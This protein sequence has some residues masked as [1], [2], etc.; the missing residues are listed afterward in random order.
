M[1]HLYSSYKRVFATLLF[2]FI[3][4]YSKANI[5]LVTNT[6]VSGP[7]SF[8]DALNQANWHVGKD[9]I[10]FNI[11]GSGPFVLKPDANGF[12]NI[13]DGVYI[14]GYSQPG[15]TAGAFTSRKILIILDGANLPVYLSG[16]DII[17]SNVEIAGLNVRNFGESGIVIGGGVQNISVWG[18][19]IGTNETGTAA[20]SNGR[21]GVRSDPFA[22]ANSTNI[23]IGTNGDGV[24]DAWEGNIISGNRDNGV[25]FMLVKNSK[26]SGNYIGIGATGTEVIGNSTAGIVLDKS[27]KSNLIGTDGNGTSDALEGNVIGNNGKYG[28]W[29]YNSSDSNTVAGNKI[30]LNTSNNAAP[31][32]MGIIVWNSS[33][34][35][36]GVTNN[37]VQSNTVS[38][39]TDYGIKLQAGDYFA[40]L[41]GNTTTHNMIS[42]N[43]I[44][45]FAPGVADR[46]NGIF[47][48]YAESL[49]G[50]DVINN[51]I[52]SNND[53]VNDALE[54]NTIAFNKQ[55]GVSTYTGFAG[56]GKLTGL[57]ISKNRMYGNVE[58]GIDLKTDLVAG[59][60]VSNN[61]N[62]P[63]TGPNNYM[64][65]PVLLNI[66]ESGDNFVINGFSDPGAI[67]EFY[68]AD[69]THPSNPLPTGFTRSFGEG[70]IAY[71]RVREDGILDNITDNSNVVGTYD[72]T[73]EG[74]NNPAIITANRF[75]FTIPKALFAG[76]TTTS[77]LT[78]TATDANGNTSEFS[79]VVYPP[80]NA[81]PL[82]VD[83]I[84]FKAVLNAGKA[85]LTWST[86]NEV[87]NDHFD[88]ERSSDGRT[89]AKLGAV[90]ASHAP[91]GNYTFVDASP[92]NNNYYRLKQVDVNGDFKYSKVVYLQALALQ[93]QISPNPFV[94]HLNVSYNL[95][96]A[97]KVKVY[98]YDMV[99]RLIKQVDLQ[100]NK[101]YNSQSVSS[102]GYLP[103]GQYVL[104][105][106]GDNLQTQV[107]LVK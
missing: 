102:L 107:R 64:N 4:I 97:G 63:L 49:S 11:A 53:G 17:S 40:I 32:S 38:S 87:S 100:G 104:K 85:N 99:G 75:Q 84:S 70:V 62:G 5:Y 33:A 93:M 68:K 19:F 15:S 86:E 55:S 91:V 79:G 12:P 66:V 13:I 2:F 1:K 67:I 26:I 21:N 47:G 31:N 101:G 60:G 25:A 30:G 65:A 36:I 59:R 54:G 37:A 82:P 57:T 41:G 105:L 96:N 103:S 56:T 76:L 88:V 34:N 92:L 23:T 90:A 42:G 6:N 35:I 14:N 95:D 9:T 7:G 98:V 83:F 80:V 106:V 58:L 73:F 44:G 22:T 46:G 72:R 50:Y 43:N 27:S 28:V 77:G 52:G 16:L 89:F 69:G 61:H 74:D 8:G 20:A 29:L 51:W 18:S 45:T 48:V 71:M 39:N 94:D 78:A 81:A 24:Q 10:N 3:I